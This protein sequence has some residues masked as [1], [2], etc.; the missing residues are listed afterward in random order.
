MRYY[1]RMH[2]RHPE[3]SLNAYHSE[4]CVVR[5][6]MQIVTIII[7]IIINNSVGQRHTKIFIYQLPTD[8][9]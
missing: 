8:S 6:Q 1:D 5:W 4:R 3:A 2:L 9:V 7:I